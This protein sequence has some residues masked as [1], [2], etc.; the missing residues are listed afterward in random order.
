[1]VNLNHAPYEFKRTKNLLKVKVMQDV[2]LKIIGFEE[3]SGR[4][5]KTLGRI[6]VDYKGNTLGVGSGFSDAQREWLWAH[7]AYL[8]GR[9][10]TVQY[11]EETED[12]D[13]KKSLRFPVFKELREEGKEVSYN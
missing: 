6:N 1:M 8:I 11:F 2:D 13:G 3:G 12:A 10:I 5:A 4:L 9:V 7:R